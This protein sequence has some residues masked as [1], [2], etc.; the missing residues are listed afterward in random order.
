MS[1]IMGI[2]LLLLAAV[3]SATAFGEPTFTLNGT[4]TDVSGTPVPDAEVY[5]YRTAN[6][7]RSADFISPKTTIDGKYRLVVPAGNY[8]G[9]ARIKQGERFGPLQIGQ[10]HSGDPLQIII[11]EEPVTAADFTVADLRE[12]AQKRPKGNLDV[13]AVS[14]LITDREGRPVDNAY[15]FARTGELQ[16]TLPEY[17]SAWTGADGRFTLLLPPGTYFWGAT[18]EFP[19]PV[20]PK[21]AGAAAADGTEIKLTLE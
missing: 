15:A 10:R 4:I 16:A 8:W 14:G 18:R 9:V 13:V 7:R 1:R 21:L 17:L 11:G 3:L 2:L 6:T 20:V 5:L 12:M 19:T